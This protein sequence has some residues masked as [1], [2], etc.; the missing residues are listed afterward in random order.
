MPLTAVSSRISSSS[1]SVE[2]WSRSSSPE[3]TCSASERR[4]LTFARESPI[5]ARSSSGS[6]ARTSSGAGAL[7][8]EA[9]EDPAPHD[10][11]DLGRELLAH[12]RA[13]QRRVMV[14]VAALVALEPDVVR[15]D[16]RAEQRI[17]G[18]QVVERGVGI[19][20]DRL[21]CSGSGTRHRRGAYAAG[22]GG[23]V[24]GSRAVRSEWS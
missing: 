23:R 22:T 7:P 14:P 3:A 1:G 8:A 6:S 24:H 11:R 21:C 18:A 17:G 2:T 19:E 5:A 12:D 13:D 9:L 15:V 20:A 10:A 16:Q 4:K